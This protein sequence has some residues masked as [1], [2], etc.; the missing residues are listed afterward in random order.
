LDEYVG[1]WYT[2]SKG[3]LQEA[4]LNITIQNNKL[5]P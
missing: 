3:Q 1:I 4:G 2:I 5:L